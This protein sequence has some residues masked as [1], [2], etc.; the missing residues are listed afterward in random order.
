M[1]LKLYDGDRLD[2]EAQYK[3]S[4]H[5]GLTHR[6]NTFRDNIIDLYTHGIVL[7]LEYLTITVRLASRKCHIS[8]SPLTK[9]QIIIF[10]GMSKTV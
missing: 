5:N 3:T 4:A 7:P 1:H 6:Q 9:V 2:C 8:A 10:V